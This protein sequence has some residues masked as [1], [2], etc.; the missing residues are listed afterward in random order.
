MELTGLLTSFRSCI[1]FVLHWA[2]NIFLLTVK[3][4]AYM[5]LRTDDRI[6]QR[7]FASQGILLFIIEEASALV[8]ATLGTICK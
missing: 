4:H 1:G 8:L 3:L 5:G 7:T 6:G 2:A